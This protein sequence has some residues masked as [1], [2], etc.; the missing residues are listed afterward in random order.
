M[1]KLMTSLLAVYAA[2]AMIGCG[3][4]ND[5]G[6][7]TTGVPSCAAG[8]YWNGYVCIA[9]NPGTITPGTT[10][11]YYDYT[12]Y[13]S[14]D[15]WG[16][17]TTQNGNMT[18][19][20]QAAFEEFLK[21]AMG[22]CDRSIWGVEYGLAKCSNWVS[23]SF[24]LEFSMDSSMKPAV[25]FTAYPAINW[26]QYSISFGINGGGMA[27]NPLYL[28]QNNTFNLI[29]QS[30]GFEIRA[31]G[32]Y[33]NGGGLKLIQIQVPVGTIADGTVAYELYFPYNGQP[34]KIATGKLVRR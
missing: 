30:K 8:Q 18:I 12:R 23:G 33:W 15:Y 24:Q 25:S 22:V 5:G 3:N 10:V 34:T 6:G 11:R 1:K 16:R 2:F 27:F 20:H 31:Q 4:N 28:N 32:S 19:V 7:V 9:N 26:Y 17:L 14:V 13:F 29:N 21:Y